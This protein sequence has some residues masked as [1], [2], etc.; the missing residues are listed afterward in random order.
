[1]LRVI[2]LMLFMVFAGGVSGQTTGRIYWTEWWSYNPANSRIAR[3]DVDGSNVETLLDGFQ[4]GTGLKDLAIDADSGKLYWSNRSSGI[5][6]RSNLDGTGR[7]T[8]LT[9]VNAIGLAL[10]SGAEKIYWTDYTYSDPRIRRANFDGT[11]VEDLVSASSGCVLEGIALDLGSGYLYWAERMDQQIWRA[12]LNGSGATLLLECWQGIG[13]PWGLALAGGR[14]YWATDESI[15]S[16]FTDGSDIQT[17]VMDLADSPRSLEMDAVANQLYWVTGSSYSGMVQRIDLDGTNLA[18]L[19]TDLYYGY[20]LALEPTSSTAVPD[21]PTSI[22]RLE[23][24][25]NPFNPSTLISFDL[26][27]AQTVRVQIYTI[28]GALVSTLLH[29]W[30]DSGPHTLVWNGLDVRGRTL[31]SGTYICRVAA[32]GYEQSRL[33]TLVR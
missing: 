33:M 8:V 10:D 20:G 11:G 17:L 13:H 16:A 19:M 15:M 5:I 6:E 2:W 25:P 1:M 31:P 26:L 22:T 32:S 4:A 24:H 29:Q 23:N 18:T 27:E 21:A 30:R 28:E 7:E 3:A 12:N 14:I 9:D